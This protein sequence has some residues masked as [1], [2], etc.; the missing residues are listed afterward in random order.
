MNKVV[1]VRPSR[2][3]IYAR[4]LRKLKEKITKDP[5]TKGYEDIIAVDKDIRIKL[6]F[7]GVH[8]ISGYKDP[9]TSYEGFALANINQIILHTIETL[10]PRDFLKI[11]PLDKQYDGEKYES[12]DYF[13][14]MEAI[15]EYGIDRRIE[16]AIDFLFD[17]MNLLT[18][19][20]FVRS[21]NITEFIITDTG[22]ISPVSE[23]F[24]HEGI[25]EMPTYKGNNGT[26]YV[27]NKFGKPIKL[28]KYKN[29]YVRRVK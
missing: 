27:V 22:G 19:L 12:K 18:R 24:H 23:F 8:C 20:Y 10:T 28:N 11:F 6:V 13:S 16:N 29:S 14:S 15:E 4:N 21:L 25:F 5:F 26:E 17:Y 1:K 9:V 3:K 2:A 7:Y